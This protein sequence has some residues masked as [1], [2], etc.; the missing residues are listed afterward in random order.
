M[1]HLDASSRCT[2]EQDLTKLP[3]DKPI[4]R[5]LPIRLYKKIATI[6]LPD[7]S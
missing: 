7:I 3:Q 2:N 6:N 1:D 4:K 5:D